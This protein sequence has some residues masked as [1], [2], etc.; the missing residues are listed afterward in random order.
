MVGIREVAKR[1]GVSA[2]TVSRVLNNDKT[3]TVTPETREKIIESVNFFNYSKKK[4][5]PKVRDSI[6]MI[7]TVSE[8]KELE[9]LYFR[10]IRIGIEKEAKRSNISL[11]KVIRLPETSLDMNMFNDCA[12]ILLIGQVLPQTIEE[13]RATRSEVIVIDDPSAPSNVDAVYTD[14]KLPTIK[15][16]E[17]LYKKGHRNMIFIGGKR[18][19]LD[20]NGK[21]FITEGD[22]RQLAYEE[23]M[24]EKDLNKYKKVYLG[25]WTTLDGLSLGELFLKDYQGKTMPTAI[26]VASDPIAVGVYRALQRHNIKIPQDV[27]VV[28]FDNIEVAEYLTPSL[29]TV[30]IETEEIGKIAVRL[31]KD[32]INKTR[33]VP[34]RVTVPSEII[35][36]ESEQETTH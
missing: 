36:R 6:G 24:E 2:A 3:M 17:R 10:A 22:Q 14:L 31:A 18:I 34:I 32:H 4:Y 9:D 12:A 29:S 13:I 16:L 7:T 25:D 26:V 8:I 35:I 28:S 19:V 15:H 33:K 21:E 23:W 27:S 11:K 5:S 1:A 20:K 30:N